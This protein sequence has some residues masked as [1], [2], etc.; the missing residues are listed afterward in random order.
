MQEAILTILIVLSVLFLVALVAGVLF[1]TKYLKRPTN[2]SAEQLKEIGALHQQI[3]S[4]TDQ[5]KVN[6]KLSV[7]E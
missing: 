4:V 7:A 3:S 1:I 2:A 6:L 5:I